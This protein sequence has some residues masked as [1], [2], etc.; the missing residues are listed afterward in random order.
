MRHD[1]A[2]ETVFRS[3][4][5]SLLTGRHWANFAGEPHFTKH[6][7]ILR[8]RLVA[9][10]GNHG[11]QQGQVSTGLFHLDPANH[12]DEDILIR[13]LQAAV[14]MQHRQQHGETVVIHPHRHPARIG[15]LGVIHQRL[16]LH[17]QRSGALPNHHHD[18]AG[19]LL[20]SPAKENGR[21]IA[22]LPHSLPGH[23]KDAKLVDRP[24]TVLVGAQGTKTGV[25]ATIEQHGAVDTV[26]QH[27]GAGQRTILGHMAHHEDGHVVLLG[28]A[29]EQRCR[30]PHLRDGTGRRLHIRHMHHLDGVDHHDLR[31]L[32]LGNQADLLD[33][34]L[35]QHPQL[36]GRQ[37]EAIGAHRHLLEG[38]LTCDI[39]GFHPLRQTAHGLQQQGRLACPR[40]AADKDG[41]ARHHAA[42]KYPIQLL[43]AG[44]ET[45]DLGGS[46]LCQCLHLTA[47]CTGITGIAGTLARGH[48][49]EAHLGNGVPLLALTA[50]ALPACEVG[51][52]FGTNISS[53]IFGH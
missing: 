37:A 23:G 14:T 43:E 13:H 25:M 46:Y 30:L 12:V 18:G 4:L 33:A 44:G 3:L 49:P 45:G 29:S 26:F 40:V 1:G 35:R 15:E 36:V 50:L 48:R 16:Q 11:Q 32:L 41:R 27:L 2:T 34:G 24:K 22:D 42:T 38:L 28:V 5:Q 9:E 10:A 8:Q 17:Q 53:F 31:L 6:H 20:L 19:S 51:T 7:Q 21:G 47:N 39:E 52:T